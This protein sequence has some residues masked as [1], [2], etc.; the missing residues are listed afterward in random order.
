MWRKGD[1][2]SVF[3]ARRAEDGLKYPF[4][5]ADG[6]QAPNLK[7]GEMAPVGRDGGVWEDSSNTRTP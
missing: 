2:E 1:L 7:T 5:G 4:K 6:E 3:W